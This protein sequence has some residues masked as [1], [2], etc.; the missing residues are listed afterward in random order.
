[1]LGM[2]GYEQ[3]QYWATRARRGIAEGPLGLL[4]DFIC[5]SKEMQWVRRCSYSLR[6]VDLSIAEAMSRIAD[7]PPAHDS[8]RHLRGRSSKNFLAN[9]SVVHSNFHCQ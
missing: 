4:T 8:G 9:R 3:L 2:V 7:A 6:T 5:I 1:M